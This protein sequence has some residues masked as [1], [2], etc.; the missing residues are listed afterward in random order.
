MDK[1]EAFKLG[2][3][4]IQFAPWIELVV[5]AV[6]P[7]RLKNLYNFRNQFRFRLHIESAKIL[8]SM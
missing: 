1:E 8:I 2:K 4:D 5:K 7:Q 3:G 6:L